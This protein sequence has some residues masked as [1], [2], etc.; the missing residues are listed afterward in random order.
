MPLR[1][2]NG[3][4]LIRVYFKIKILKDTYALKVCSSMKCSY[5]ATKDTVKFAFK[6]RQYLV[7]KLWYSVDCKFSHFYVLNFV[8]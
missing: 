1:A 7:L 4:A 2:Q 6:G 5:H 3:V 8:E